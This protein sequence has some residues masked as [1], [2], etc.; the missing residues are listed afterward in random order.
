MIDVYI[1]HRK[2][3]IRRRTR[4]LLRR[5]KQ[6]AHI[7]EALIL[8][9]GDIDGII[10]TIKTSPDS[11]T[12]K[13]RL[14]NR[15]LVLT[16]AGQL[17]RLLPEA[18]VTRYGDPNS[19]YRMT[20]VQAQAILTMQLQRLTGLEIEKL[21]KEYGELILE[22][23]DYEGILANENLVLDIIREDLYE[24]REKL[25]DKRRTEIVE[26]VGDFSM[27]ELIP[28]EEVVV[29]ISH[30]GYIKRTDPDTYR[31][32]GRGGRGIKGGD[33]REGDFIEN[34][35]FAST[36]DYLLVFTNRGRV[37]WLRVFDIPAGARTARGRSIANLLSMQQ[38]EVHKAILTVKKFEE[39][40]IFFATEKGV[41]KKTPLGA[42]SRPRTS[43]IIALTLDPDDELIGVELTDGDHEIV[44][45][46]REGMAVRFKEEGVRQ[47]GRSAHGVRGMTLEG[48]D[49][50]VD[51]IVIRTGASVLTVCENGYGKRTSLEEYRLT[52]R[53]GKGVINIKT[54]ERNG[55]V[56]AMKAVTDTDELM[57]ITAKG[58]ALRTDLREI[59]EIGR[60]T[61]GVRVIRLDEDD[62]LVAV[63]R[64]VKEDG[65][66]ERVGSA[67]PAPEGARPA[68][69]EPAETEPAG[70]S[71]E[72]NDA[73][74]NDD[75]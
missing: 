11:P 73:P 23:A 19:P 74:P 13:E 6:K 66:E 67:P 51:M 70:E 68:E 32:Q 20:A 59:R 55:S 39:K 1:N 9:I 36:H 38:G 25:A 33:T 17:H 60:A 5:A 35:F 52:K 43:G 8:A 29:T 58:I 10:E 40:Y 15:P 62:K 56:V 69:P 49:R 47:M 64:A 45:A 50:V 12:A 37:Y 54:T 71:P 14:M 2:E 41:V 75:E 27:E 18:F 3:V 28:D 16:E 42:F 46:S 65:D 34:L 26:A 72:A 61:Q 24:I 21:A 57:L 4:F 31:K 48:S 30:E 7:L 44:L 53:G 63:A 22:I